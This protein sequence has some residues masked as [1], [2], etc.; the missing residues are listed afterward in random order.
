MIYASLNNLNY[1]KKKITIS[2]RKKDHTLVPKRLHA[3][4]PSV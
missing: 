1:V 4:T 2:Y 3:Q